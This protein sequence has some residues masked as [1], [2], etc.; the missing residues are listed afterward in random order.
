[1]ER[2]QCIFNVVAYVTSGASPVLA[3]LDWNGSSWD[4]WSP[5]SASGAITITSPVQFDS[6]GDAYVATTANTASTPSGYQWPV[7][8]KH[9][10]GTNWTT[11]GGGPVS[12][13]CTS[14]RVSLRIGPDGAPYIALEETI[15][16]GYLEVSLFTLVDGAWSAVGRRGFSQ[17]QA[18][19]FPTLSFDASGAPWIAYDEVGFDDKKSVQKYVGGAD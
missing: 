7:V 17:G 11:L 12:L 5:A 6:S 4:D 15:D 2:K 9:V 19:E 14:S 3:V 18:G 16:T 1:V 13:Y 10:S 8:L